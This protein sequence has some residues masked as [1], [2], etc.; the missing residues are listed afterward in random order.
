MAKDQ[1]R[2]HKP[3]IEIFEFIWGVSKNRGTVPHNGWFTMEK[4]VKMDD[5]GGKP[6][7]FWKP[8]Y[9][10]QQKRIQVSSV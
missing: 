9:L 1:G 8:P 2:S 6:T 4:P 10:V 5:L 3:H 7:I